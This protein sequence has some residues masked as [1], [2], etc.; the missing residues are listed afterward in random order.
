MGMWPVLGELKREEGKLPGKLDGDAS[1]GD[2]TGLLLEVAGGEGW[3][4]R[5]VE[6]VWVGGDARELG[7]GAFLINRPFSSRGGGGFLLIHKRGGRR[8]GN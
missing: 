4:S 2:D 3:L 6:R 5:D 1:C 7:G 8:G